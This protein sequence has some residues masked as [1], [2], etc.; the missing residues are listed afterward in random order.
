MSEDFPGGSDGKVSACSGQDLGLIPGLG[1]SPGG[2]HGNPLQ[3][4]CLENSH[5]QRRLTGYSP[6]DHKELDTT[7][8]LSTLQHR[9]NWTM[10]RRVGLLEQR[11]RWKNQRSVWDSE[12]E[13]EGSGPGSTIY[14][15]QL[16][17]NHLTEP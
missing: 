7:E 9:R 4:S 1:R 14:V 15:V 6:W 11:A 5:G 17:E 8:W 13:N 3:Y 16:S 10:E 2:G 12:L